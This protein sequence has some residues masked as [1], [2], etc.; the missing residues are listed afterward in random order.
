MKTVKHTRLCTTVAGVIAGN[1]GLSILPAMAADP[2]AATAVTNAELLH[3]LEA[4]EEQNKILAQKVEKLEAAQARASNAQPLAP[5]ESAMPNSSQVA[6]ATPATIPSASS[7]TVG[8]YGEVEYTRPSK[9]PSQANVDIARAVILLQ[10][11][12]DERT[13]FGGEFEWEHAI[14]S[15]DDSGE[16]EVEQL[17]LERDLKAGLRARA[18]LML[19]PVG[20]I[21]ENHEPTA[22]FGVQRPEVDQKIVPS[23]WREVGLGLLGDTEGSLSYELAVTSAP[24]L[25][26]WEADST[27]GRLRGPLQAIHGEGQFASVR[28]GGVV[29]ALNWRGIPGLLVGGS[30]FYAGIG[31]HQ[32]DFAGGSSKLLFLDAHARYAIAGFEFAGEYERG[33]ISHTEALNASFAA[34]SIPDPTLVPHLFYGGYVQAAYRLWQYGDIALLPFVRY[35][36]L[37]TAAG[38]GNLPVSSGGISQPDEVIWT[39]GGTLKFGEGVVFKADYRHYK[40]NPYPDADHFNL[41]NSLNLGIGLSF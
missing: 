5:T 30:V 35:E 19:M 6:Q 3:K 11:R 33:T 38:F 32:P 37:N 13:R 21:N 27:E 31:Q 39:V 2:P 9:V 20:L 29:G 12:F 10:H 34:S 26:H 23:T 40:E 8:G 15:S 1:L 36:V 22:F 17:W 41:G 7:T 14:T 28:D 24:N 25:S 4:L 18:G 16:A